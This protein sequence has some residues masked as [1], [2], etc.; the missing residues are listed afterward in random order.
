MDSIVEYL[1]QAV[2]GKGALRF[3]IQ[4]TVAILLGVRAGRS[5]ART[6]TTPYFWL[7]LFGGGD[8]SAALVEALKHISKVLVV[9]IVLDA[10][11]Q[12]VLY[13]SIRPGWAITVG[14]IIVFVP[15]GLARGITNRVS[16]ARAT[17]GTQE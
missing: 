5:D 15:Y 17:D 7:L 6:R 9:A 8:R 3:I 14:V 11:F 1:Q 16:S 2:S 13:Q 12:Y 10:V 4:P